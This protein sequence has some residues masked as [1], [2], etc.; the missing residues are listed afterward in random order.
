MFF[1]RWI[2]PVVLTGCGL[3]MMNMGVKWLRSGHPVKGTMDL[4]AGTGFIV[5]GL[6]LPFSL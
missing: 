4:V 2:A 5:I 6:Y 3:F 1:V